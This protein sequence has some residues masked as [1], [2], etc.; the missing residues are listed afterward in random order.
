M[1]ELINHQGNIL[2]LILRANYHAE[3]IQ[4]FTPKV[5]SQQLA[6]M[7]HPPDH[8]INPHIHNK[9]HRDVHLTQ[10]VLFI[11]K[12]RVQVDLY[13]D[14]KQYIRSAVL[15]TGDVILLASGGHG[16]TML[17]ETEMIEV[18]QGPYAGNGD[19]ERFEPNK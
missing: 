5:F 16:F 14:T 7:K 11:R 10:E 4:F 8:Q 2:A 12:G 6:Y 9:V 17:E 15:T 19:K 13:D 3:G 18:K 1:I